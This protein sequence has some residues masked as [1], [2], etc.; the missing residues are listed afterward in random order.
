MA[1]AHVSA[2]A[3]TD[4]VPPVLYRECAVL[5]MKANEAKWREKGKFII[6]HALYTLILFST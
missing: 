6:L 1:C 4:I 5:V 3:A 2:S